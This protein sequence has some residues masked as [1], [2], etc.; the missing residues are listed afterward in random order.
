MRS[1][2][3]RIELHALSGPRRSARAK[4]GMVFQRFNL[5]PMTALQ[6]VMEAP[7]LVRRLEAQGP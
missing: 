4:I 2:A 1:S 7:V 6:N 3:E 5:F